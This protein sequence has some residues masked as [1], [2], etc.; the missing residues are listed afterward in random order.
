MDRITLPPYV[1]SINEFTIAKW[2]LWNSDEYDYE[3]VKTN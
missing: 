1:H 2:E 3:P